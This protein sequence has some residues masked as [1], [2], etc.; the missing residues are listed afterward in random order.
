MPQYMEQDEGGDL[1]HPHNT[2]KGA[3]AKTYSDVRNE[4][5]HIWEMPLPQPHPSTQ[6]GMKGV[7]D[8]EGVMRGGGRGDVE[9]NMNLPPMPAPLPMPPEI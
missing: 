6:G 9:V 3:H 1:H 2:L 4:Y 7:M 5:A 8:R